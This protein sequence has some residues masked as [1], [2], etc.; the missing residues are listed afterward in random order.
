[1][2]GTRRVRKEAWQSPIATVDRV[3][4]IYASNERNESGTKPVII[5]QPVLINK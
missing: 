2:I 1:M 3:F 5:A 4:E